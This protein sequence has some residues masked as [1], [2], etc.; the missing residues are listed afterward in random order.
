[1]R[2]II[3]GLLLSIACT[4]SCINARA[5]TVTAASCSSGDVQAAIN[6]ALTGDTVAVP[7]GSCT[8]ASPVTIAN[9]SVTLQ[10]QTVC[11]GSGNPSQND[12]SCVDSTVI[13]ITVPQGL[14]VS[15]SATGFVAI[16]GFTFITNAVTSNGTIVLGGTHGQLGFRF[17]HN[18]IQML[19]SGSNAVFAYNGYGL[20]DHIYWQ[21]TSGGAAIPLNFGGDF[22]T[23]GYANWNDATNLGSSE[24]LYVEDSYYTT[25]HASTEGFFDAYYGTKL[26]IRYNTIVGNELGGWHGTDSG[27]YRSVL[28][29]EIYDN[30]VSNSTGSILDVMNTRGG[31]LLFFNNAVGGSTSWHA[32]DLQY[33]RISEPTDAV[34]WGT[35]TTGLNWTPLSSDPTNINSDTN[36]LNA[37]DWQASHSYA[38]G[39]AIGPTSNNAGSYNYQNSGSCTSG[40]SRPS[41]NQSV[42]GTT[43]DGTC[44]WTNVAGSTTAGPGGS[45]FCAANPDTACSSDST[46]QALS[47]RDTCSRYSDTNGGVYPF[48]DQPG[49]IHN[50]VLAPNYAWGNSGSGLPSPLLVTDAATSDIIQPNVD[51]YNAAASFNGTSGTGNGLLS[52]RPS[53]CAPQVAYWATD[54]NTLYQCSATNTWTPYYTPYTYPHPLQG[55]DPSPPSN[56]QA[57]PQ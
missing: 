20:L 57:I 16:T 40:S 15:S 43:S 8:W 56:L 27:Q 7:S 29:G 19:V 42:A 52:A 9:K 13:T 48:R 18:H 38:S 45:G 33:Y 14:N 11:T 30:S 47:G 36:T 3:K 54:T 23:R 31:S 25:S 28:L 2:R 50:Q 53:T 35:A 34:T 26:V 5:N 44:T 32:V 46:C 22:A 10:G 21:D 41:F 17:H 55:T 6:S 49:R 4:L 12:L 39:A 37:S 24:A 51:Y 1:M